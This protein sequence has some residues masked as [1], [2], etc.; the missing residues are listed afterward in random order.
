MN[1]TRLLVGIIT[2]AIMVI[3]G[4]AWAG[5]EEKPLDNAGVIQMTKADLGDD[6]IIAK[7]N[8][9]RDV[10][11]D[12][13]TDDLVR[14]KEA[15]VTK[16]VITAMLNKTAVKS[17]PVSTEEPK[18]LLSTSDGDVELKGTDGDVKTI[19]A[20]FVGMRRFINYTDLRATTRTKDRRPSF[21]VSYDRDPS[22]T[23]WYVKLDQDNDKDEMNRSIDVES[24]GTWGGVL[25]SAPDEDYLVKTTLVE[26]KPGLWRLTPTRDLRPGEYGLYIGKG[27]LSSYLYDF[28]I[29]K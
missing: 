21:L 10:K 29:D 6:I 15:G 12:M 23:C 11:F 20:P 24:P 28:G 3:V 25:S 9:A 27:E 17:A 22:R 2:A 13:T 7:I 14:L 4:G 18:V 19:V 1:R 16:E 26:E 5:E 8:S